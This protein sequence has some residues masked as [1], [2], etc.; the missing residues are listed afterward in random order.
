MVSVEKKNN[1]FE[2]DDLDQAVTAADDTGILSNEQEIIKEEIF[3][4]TGGETPPPDD[5]P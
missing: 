2:D 1:V 5:V 4:H 3:E